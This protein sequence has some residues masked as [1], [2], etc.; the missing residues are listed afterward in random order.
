MIGTRRSILLTPALAAALS[1]SLVWTVLP[2]AAQDTKH[3][4]PGEAPSADEVARI[5][6]GCESADN[7]DGVRTRQIMVRKKGQ[8]AP[9][10]GFSVPVQFELGSA[11]LTPAALSSLAGIAAGLDKVL[12]ANPQARITIEGHADR[13]GE[14]MLNKDLSARRAMAVRDYLSSRIQV[15]AEALQVQGFGS[16][17]P[18]PG[19]DPYAG[20]NRR[21]EFRRVQ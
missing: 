14:E 12:Q 16:S 19:T 6:G 8:A 10:S 15:P 4:K 2:A 13:S 18:I 17:R 21:V 5:L 3:F 1:A 20:A 7:C 11:N 9:P